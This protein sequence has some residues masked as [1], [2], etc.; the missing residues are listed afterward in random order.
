MKSHRQH[1]RSIK[2]GFTLVE[3]L[4]VITIIAILASLAVPVVNKVME[5]ANTLRIKATMKDIQVA[6][7]NYRS[8][9]NRF[10]ILLPSSSGGDD[11]AP[12]LTNGTNQIINILMAQTDPAASPNMNARNIKYVDLPNAR[13]SQTF[14]IIDPSGGAGGGAPIQLVDMWGQPYTI[15]LDTNYDNRI[16]NPDTQNIDQR[17]SARAPK[18]LS[19]TSGMLSRGRDK[20]INTRD[21]IVSWR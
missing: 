12:I 17:I 15:Y 2:R 9:Y 21:D 1:Y 5:N 4:V 6:I 16:A 18:F 3:L 14:G 20:T 19:S 8:E 10:P 11:V 13:N 7:G